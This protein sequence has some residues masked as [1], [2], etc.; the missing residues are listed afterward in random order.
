MPRRCFVIGCLV[1]HI[2]TQERQGQVSPRS[3]RG[4]HSIYFL[5][6]ASHVFKII[7]Y[8]MGPNPTC[9]VPL[10]PWRNREDGRV[11]RLRVLTF[12]PPPQ[13]S[14]SSLFFC[15]FSLLFPSLHL[16]S[17]PLFHYCVHSSTCLL[18]KFPPLILL[19]LYLGQTQ[20]WP[21]L[22]YIPFASRRG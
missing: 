22:F 10:S 18:R 4:Q 2:N 12:P 13:S 8:G 9:R 7:L 5:R 3:P 17:P 11:W 16:L 1:F 15:P 21:L 14:S 20:G 6:L 19:Y